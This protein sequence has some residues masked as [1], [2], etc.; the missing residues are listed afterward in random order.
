MTLRQMEF[1]LAVYENK[2]VSKAA[3][4]LFV[5]QQA[6]SKALRN[7]EEELKCQLLVHSSTGTT[8]TQYGIYVMEEFRIILRKTEYITAHI[9]EMKKTPK[10]PL[11][12]GMSY[13]MI[14]ALPADLLPSFSKDFPDIE[15]IYTDY[16]DYELEKALSE[17]LCDIAITTGFRNESSFQMELL[18]REKC[19]LCI[20]KGHMYY[21]RTD[22]TMNDLRDQDFVMFSSKYLISLKFIRSCHYAGF[23]PKILQTSGDFNSLKEL[24]A[25]TGTLFVVPEHTVHPDEIG[26]S[27][28]PFPD[29]VYTWDIYFAIR[30]NKLFTEGMQ[31]FYTEIKKRLD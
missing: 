20:P 6:I 4:K 18:K 27:Y 2:S 10:E 24:A 31:M 11:H 26:F 25:V 17:G 9:N 16:T 30:P 19:F 7:L 5:S 13:G 22:L 1:L 23:E 14:S 12:V 21:G 29:S 15:L 28:C 8:F 3:E